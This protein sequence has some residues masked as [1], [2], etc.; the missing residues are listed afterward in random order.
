MQAAAYCVMYEELTGIPI[1]NTVILIAVDN[2]DPQVFHGKRDNYI[3]DFMELRDSY[4]K[5][6]GK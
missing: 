2:E 6:Y 5:I 3:D 4:R 1:T